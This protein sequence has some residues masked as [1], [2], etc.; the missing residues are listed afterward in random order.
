MKKALILSSVASMI[1]QF[2]MDNIHTLKKLGYEVH[3]LTNF[4]NAG[5]IPKEEAI[6]LQE[7]LTNIDVKVFD[8]NINRNP[9]SIDNIYALKKIKKIIN[10]EKYYVIHCHSPIGGIL[11]RIAA[12]KARK[13]QTKI[14]Y[15]AHGFH[16]YKGAPI[17]NWIIFYPLE[18]F[19]S[20]F[21]DILITINSEDY[22]RAKKFHM[23]KLER[24]PGVGL[25]TE[26]YNT[27]NSNRLRK[28]KSLNIPIDSFVILSVGE[29]ND[30]K[31]HIVIM[32]ALA[33]INNKKIHYIIC[34]NGSNKEKLIA[35]SEKLDM[36][37]NVHLLGYRSDVNEICNMSDL[38]AFPSKREG[39]GLA[40]LESMA[41]SLPIITSNV[42]GIN[43][44]SINGVTGYSYSPNDYEGF[45]QGIVTYFE[46]PNMATSIGKY[47]KV[48]VQK[49]D[50]KIV[51]KEMIRIY[52]SINIL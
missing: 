31:N 1:S 37:E 24:I 10:K 21:T 43:D 41:S 25:D 3:V 44:Y 27:I 23:K 38:F 39:L 16:F 13:K 17:L 15:T 45:A 48:Y 26:R 51:N 8:V 33:K 40:C 12:M 6:I 18:K 52:S 28:K 5:N 22:E 9:F 30:N 49:F 29:L 14:I 35:F 34:G 7:R 4:S 36:S 20:R 32:K 46:N 2:N 19:F 42:H 11:T 50:K 47:N